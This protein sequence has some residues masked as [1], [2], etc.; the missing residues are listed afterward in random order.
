LDPY[1]YWFLLALVL[2]ILEMAT[3][4]FYLLVVAVALAIGGGVALVSPDQ[5]IAFTLSAVAGVVGTVILRMK[6]RKLRSAASDQ[7]L[8]IG[9]PVHGVV[10]N[11]DGSARAVYRGTEWD[12][13][14]ESV[15]SSRDGVFYIKAMRG[16]TL[17]LSHEKPKS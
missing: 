16:S 10:W 13:E 4:T 17:I 11:E 15:D 14:A 3:N 8:D 9:Q 6:R 7:S 1:V 5:T 12:A 2:V